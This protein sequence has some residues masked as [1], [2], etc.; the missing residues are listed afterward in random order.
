MSRAAT[1]LAVLCAILGLAAAPHAVAITGGQ[2]TSAGTFPWI[3]QVQQN[4][5]P[6]WFTACTGTLIGPRFVLTAAHC[7]QLFPDVG[8]P[9]QPAGDPLMGIRVV[10]SDGVARR[11]L[12][13][14]V[15]ADF[16]YE[17]GVGDVAV[18]QL[19]ASVRAIAPVRLSARDPR[20]GDVG[21]GLGYG[22]T[23]ADPNVCIVAL[24]LAGVGVRH[25]IGVGELREDHERVLMVDGKPLD[26]A[27]AALCGTPP[28]LIC[29]KGVDGVTRDG[30]S[31]G[32]L[33]FRQGKRWVE[34]GVV[35]DQANTA[36]ANQTG[37][38]NLTTTWISVAHLRRFLRNFEG[39]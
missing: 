22:C 1:A 31:G 17:A 7:T 21:T 8:Q 15:P 9:Q 39:R 29:T 26:Q 18:L 16:N 2:A 32:P 19:A 23:S 27:S 6:A 35:H 37:E 12:H 36:E 30:D 24:A 13:V 10:L 25:P 5:A 33:L 4:R 34:F 3:V 14:Y 38:G 20:L 28:T 11:L